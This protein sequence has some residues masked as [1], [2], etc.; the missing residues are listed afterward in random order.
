MRNY[1]G[2]G[3]HVC[4]VCLKEHDE[5]VLIDKSLRPTLDE[6]SFVGWAMCAEHEERWQEGYIALIECSNDRQPTLKNANRTGAIAHVRKEAWPRI[7]N[8]PAPDT[9]IAFVQQGVIERLQGMM[10]ESECESP[11]DNSTEQLTSTQEP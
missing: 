8:V 5:V 4:P 9:P 2:I 6:R 1:V 3:V 7:F 11:S 10:P